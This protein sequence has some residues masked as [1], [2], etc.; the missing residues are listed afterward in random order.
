M[1]FIKEEESMKH[2]RVPNN[3]DPEVEVANIHGI[4]NTDVP[5]LSINKKHIVWSTKASSFHM[6]HFV[7]RFSTPST[8]LV[9][10]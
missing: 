2:R 8:F 7:I 9:L 5:V 3:R 10:R 4:G 6:D 1:E